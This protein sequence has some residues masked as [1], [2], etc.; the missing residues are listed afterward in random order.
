VLWLTNGWF[1]RNEFGFQTNARDSVVQ[2]VTYLPQICETH[3]TKTVCVKLGLSSR[4]RNLA[5]GCS[6]IVLRRIFGPKRNEVRGE[7]RW[8]HNEELY[9][10]YFSPHVTGMIESRTRWAGHV[11]CV[12][13]RR[14][15]CRWRDVSEGGHLE[16]LRVD[17]ITF[18]WICKKWNGWAWPGL[19]WQVAGSCECG[20]EPSDFIKCREFPD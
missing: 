18:K 9:D 13:D 3:N 14:G 8:L 2:A 1:W 19:I 6:R 20:N 11:T 4:E 15:A 12:V 5:W 7:W 17:R 10:L 16:E